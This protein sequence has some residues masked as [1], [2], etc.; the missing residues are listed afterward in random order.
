MAR[1]LSDEV[2]SEQSSGGLWISGLRVAGAGGWFQMKTARAHE[3]NG[4]HSI[5]G[6][7]TQ[8]REHSRARKK[9]V[10]G[11]HSVQSA[12]SDVQILF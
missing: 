3:L 2:A 10:R 7:S 12:Q 4:M 9:V 1:S 11:S 8:R 6:A 5:Q